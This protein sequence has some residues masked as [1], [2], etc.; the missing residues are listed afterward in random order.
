MMMVADIRSNTGLKSVFKDA[1]E[2]VRQALTGSGDVD[3]RT[4]GFL[5]VVLD[6]LPARRETVALGEMC[7]RLSQTLTRYPGTDRVLRYWVK[8]HC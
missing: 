8:N 1:N 4:D 7:E 6:P 3:P 2:F 5:D